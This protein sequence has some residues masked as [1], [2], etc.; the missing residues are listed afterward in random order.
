MNKTC[1]FE[2]YNKEITWRQDRVCVYDLLSVLQ[3]VVNHNA[4]PKN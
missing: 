1:N 2:N 4:S 3:S